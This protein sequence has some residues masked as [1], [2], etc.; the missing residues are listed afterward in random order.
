MSNIIL[1]RGNKIAFSMRAGYDD[2]EQNST[3]NDLKDTVF[4]QGWFIPV[5]M[6]GMQAAYFNDPDQTFRPQEY[7]KDQGGIVGVKG[8]MCTLGEST[9][10][11]HQ[12]ETYRTKQTIFTPLYTGTTGFAVIAAYP[13]Q[14]DMMTMCVQLTKTIE[15]AIDMYFRHCPGDRSSYLIWKKSDV[16]RHLVNYHRPK[17][18]RLIM[19]IGL[20]K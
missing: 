9:L 2:S 14:A 18:D 6:H 12:V 11:Y 8:V 4:E 19:A 16:V 15:E 5:A 10:L 13:H 3:V 20:N 17:M 1:I 7:A